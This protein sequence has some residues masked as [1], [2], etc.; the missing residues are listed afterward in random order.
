MIPSERGILCCCY[1]FE[2]YG[3]SGPQVAHMFSDFGQFSIK[4]KHFGTI[5]CFQWSSQNPRKTSAK[6]R[7]GCGKYGKEGR[8]YDLYIYI[9]VPRYLNEMKVSGN[10]TVVLMF[11]RP[12]EST[13]N[14]PNRIQERRLAKHLRSRWKLRLVVSLEC[15]RHRTR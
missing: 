2:V 14:E 13:M 3:V 12:F 9:R 15:R 11:C 5:I 4:T 10:S 6:I 7:A 1:A 8:H